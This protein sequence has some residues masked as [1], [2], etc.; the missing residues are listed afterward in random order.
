MTWTHLLRF[1]LPTHK[2]V[3]LS[4]EEITV[5][6]KFLLLRKKMAPLKDYVADWEQS[7]GYV[8]QITTPPTPLMKTG[9]Q[10][11]K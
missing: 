2:V 7:Q 10:T 4:A 1:K 6:D 3:S 11:L 9:K 8:R 5:C